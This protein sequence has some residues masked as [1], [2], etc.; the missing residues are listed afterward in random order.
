[1]KHLFWKLW[2]L[3]DESYLYNFRSMMK[4]F[5]PDDESDDK[6]RAI[7]EGLQIAYDYT[8]NRFKES[9]KLK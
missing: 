4:T 8:K 5:E 1:M 6:E 9:S 3:N 7:Y 2:Y